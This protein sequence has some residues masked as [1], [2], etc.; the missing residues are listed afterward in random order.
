MAD[1]N[2]KPGA[3]CIEKGTI[4]LYG[5]ALV[6]GGEGEITDDSKGFSMTPE[7]SG[8]YRITLEDNYNDLRNLTGVVVGAADGGRMVHVATQDVQNGDI[9]IEWLDEL[10]AV[11]DV[12]QGSTFYIEITLKN[13][14]VDY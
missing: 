3:M 11:E 9:L 10:G 6:T 12:P 8:R 13:S 5:Q 14:T 4:K 2:Y 7:G 1:R